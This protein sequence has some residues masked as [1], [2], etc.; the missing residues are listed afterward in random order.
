[1][2]VE[3]FMKTFD[4][5][6]FLCLAL[7]SCKAAENFMAFIFGLIL[8]PSTSISGMA[9]LFDGKICQSTLN[10]FLTSCKISTAKLLELYRKWLVSQAKNCSAVYCIIDDSLLHKSGKSLPGANY[11][12]DHSRGAVCWGQSVVI[13]LAKLGEV[14]LL[15]GIELYDKTAKKFLSKIDW[16]KRLAKDFSGHFAGRTIVYLFDSWYCCQKLIDALPSGAQWVSKLKRNRIIYVGG[17][18]LSLKDFVRCVKSWQYHKVSVD[19]K[20]YWCHEAVVEVNKLGVLKIVLTKSSRHARKVSA[21]LVSNMLGATE[22]ELVRHFTQRWEIE[23]CIRTEKQ[24]LG[25]EGCM[26]RSKKALRRY[27]MLLMISYSLLSKLKK[28]VFRK[29]K[30]HGDVI[31]ELKKKFLKLRE[32]IFSLIKIHVK[33]IFAKG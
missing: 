27:W 25:F 6:N 4:E 20:V 9:E 31:K 29:A 11:A 15:F 13:C 3:D 17:Q 22:E 5:L 30:T 32:G 1:M 2:H 18:R 28:N 7:P 21:V 24:S 19:G 10:R 16:A 14:N 12:Y 23:V 26:V 8:S 33:R